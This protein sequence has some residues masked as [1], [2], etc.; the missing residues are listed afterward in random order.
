MSSDEQIRNSEQWGN[1]FLDIYE[2]QYG[3]ALQR[4]LG[5]HERAHQVALAFTQVDMLATFLRLVVKD[6]LTANTASRAE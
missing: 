1:F 5:G 4:Q 2:R 6:V 3:L